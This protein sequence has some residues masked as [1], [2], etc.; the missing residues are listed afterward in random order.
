MS[1]PQSPVE[2]NSSSTPVR[3]ALVLLA[4]AAVIYL[5]W[6]NAEKIGAILMV[7]FGFGGVIVVHEF[8]HFILGKLTG[9]KVT[10]FSVG[11]SPVLIGLRRTLTGWHVRILPTLV[12]KPGG[13][14][15][16]GALDF[17]FG[18]STKEWDTEYRIGL[19]PFGGFVA[20]MGQEDL[21]VAERSDDPRSFMNKPFLARLAA[22]LAGVTFNAISA[23]IIFMVI[24]HNGI[25][26]QAPVVGDV[27][28]NS[29]ADK[30][31]LRP[32][33]E[34]VSIES[35]TFIDFM[36]IS[37]AAALGDSN[38]PVHMMV[39]RTLADGAA[40]TF[41][42]S[43]I[44]K[45]NPGAR[46]LRFVR[47]FGIAPSHSLEI[48]PLKDDE[49]RE[50]LKKTTGLMEK[51]VV[52][53]VNG[54]PVTTGAEY[55]LAIAHILAPSATLTVRRAVEAS[56]GSSRFDIEIPLQVGV[57][58]P[59][60]ESRFKLVAILGMVP[61][62]R[63]AGDSSD[64]MEVLRAEG[65]TRAT[66][67]PE[68]EASLLLGEKRLL[69]GDIIL[70]AG[71]CE[72]PTF[73]SL[74][75]AMAEYDRQKAAH[76]KDHSVPFSEDVEVT[77]IRSAGGRSEVLT[78]PVKPQPSPIAGEAS[79]LG[80]AS[81]LD[82]MHPV[83]AQVLPTQENLGIAE[84][85]SG[86]MITSVDG[87][88]MATF[89]DVVAAIRTHAGSEVTI[90]W[91]KDGDKGTVTLNVPAGGDA[92]AAGIQPAVYIPF[93][94]ARRLYRAD[95]LSQSVVMGWKRTMLFIRQ[96]VVTI[97][98]LIS[99]ALSP[100]NLSGP[101]GI[102]AATYRIAAHSP[103][104]YYFY[105]LALISASIAVVNLLPLLPFDG[106]IIVVMLIEKIKGSP[107]SPRAL[108]IIGYAGWALVGALMLYVTFN[109]VI[110]WILKRPPI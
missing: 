6:T 103:L 29:P 96:A 12:P 43:M 75:E 7:L 102:V 105:W 51:D 64:A 72:Y 40:E 38:E 84:M 104:S 69:P 62:L 9:M 77:V 55:D 83:V 30:A 93:D 49:D 79:I 65:E 73:T 109:D 88:K 90:D 52:V 47:S 60:F 1:E 8:G 28:A 68:E 45:I 100:R 54:E 46:A 25:R 35:E 101:V 59:D 5:L 95:S 108:S 10:A 3:L 61:R 33:D 20:V 82:M 13:E 98:R 70:R 89:Y 23:L 107:I 63:Y 58:A 106:G 16:Q 24:F 53:A 31:G 76:S 87:V 48:A 18:E 67:T 4:V 21:G 94:D 42:V 56:Q 41:P 32:G 50:I 37:L 44:P 14:P 39:K 57:M 81:A 34:I 92:I 27:I 80:I 26:L 2:K 66:D 11:F 91:Q 86:A 71:E 78:F 19:I 36:N 85:P 74:R 17:T 97:P 22:I 99:G 15:E 110:M